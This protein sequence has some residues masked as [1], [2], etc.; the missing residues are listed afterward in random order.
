MVY[1]PRGGESSYDFEATICREVCLF[2]LVQ[3]T[4]GPLELES[5]RLSLYTLNP[6]YPGLRQ[7]ARLLSG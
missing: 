5:F 2:S 6:I 7:I 4:Q 1:N 3:S